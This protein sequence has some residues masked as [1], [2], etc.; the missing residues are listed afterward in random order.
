M[1]IKSENPFYESIENDVN[2]HCG[3]EIFGPL[4]C[5]IEYSI[6]RSGDIKGTLIGYN[7]TTKDLH[8]FMM[9]NKLKCKLHSI[10]SSSKPNTVVNVIDIDDVLITNIRNVGDGI[11]YG[12]TLDAVEAKFFVVKEIS[13]HKIWPEI[14]NI[15]REIQYFIDGPKEFWSGMT[16]RHIDYETGHQIDKD[17]SIP[18]DFNIPAKLEI[19]EA[20]F[21]ESVEIDGLPVSQK[22]KK[23]GVVF[24]CDQ[25]EEE[26]SDRDLLD[27]TAK[28]VE[29]MTIIASF[30][31]RNPIRW[32]M[33]RFYSPSKITENIRHV[34]YDFTQKIER[35]EMLIDPVQ[36]PEFLKRT[37]AQFRQLRSQGINLYYPLIMMPTSYHTRYMENRFTSYYQALE[38]LKDI[39]AVSNGLDTITNE[40]EYGE[41]KKRI[42]L[43]LD[44]KFSDVVINS[45]IK[46]K[47]IEL[48]RPSFWKIL[49]KMLEKHSIDWRKFYPVNMKSDRPTFIS[50]RNKWFHTNKDVDHSVL[51][52]ETERVRIITELLLIK[53]L[54]WTSSVNIDP[55]FEVASLTQESDA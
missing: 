44:S 49:D 27:L 32:Y 31:S 4:K 43:L 46:E 45:S 10:N 7:K 42:I 35:H 1:S 39:W 16:W 29:D 9:R 18:I 22:V 14:Q 3:S 36:C 51:S 6:V 8:D 21:H 53:Y 24:K 2:L 25:T 48:N 37:V 38:K 23:V 52:K 54:G 28:A 55:S 47:L 12:G 34:G 26:I 40:E 5:K 19:I 15:K 20:P 33:R 17:Y 11:K 41:I 13:L 50:T 30:A